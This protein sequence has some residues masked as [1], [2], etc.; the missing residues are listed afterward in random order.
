MRDEE[1]MR[2]SAGSTGWVLGHSDDEGKRY[3][4]PALLDK[5]HQKV[6]KRWQRPR[7]MLHNLGMV[8][9]KEEVK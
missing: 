8:S 5:A 7:Q 1:G 2:A 6:S 9:P 4:G 3:P